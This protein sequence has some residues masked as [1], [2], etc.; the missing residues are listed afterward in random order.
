MARVVQFPGATSKASEQ[1]ETQG[2][3]T[4]GSS[5]S[6][7]HELFFPQKEL[8]G[9]V[10]FLSVD[11][12]DEEK[13][14]TVLVKSQCK[15]IVDIRAFPVFDPPL[16]SNEKVTVVLRRHEV[17][18]VHYFPLIKLTSDEKMSPSTND[19]IER[20]KQKLSQIANLISLS[21]LEGLVIVLKD[22][23]TTAEVLS[24]MRKEFEA[25][26]EFNA[27]ISSRHISK[28]IGAPDE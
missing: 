25:Y 28:I 13:L 17:K 4:S 10:V 5:E 21:L 22:S 11:E 14:L 15:L 2:N 9:R 7:Q 12:L 20:R 1:P 16:Y 24:K 3:K 19:F 8:K 6:Q 26:S 27:E 18:H 23:N